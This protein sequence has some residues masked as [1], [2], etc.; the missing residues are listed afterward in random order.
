LTLCRPLECNLFP[1]TT[2]FRSGGN[3]DQANAYQEIESFDLEGY[4]VNMG[5][6]LDETGDTLY[7]GE[8]ETYLSNDELGRYVWVDGEVEELE[9]RKSTRLNSS[10]VSISYAVF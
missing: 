3:K 4:V 5:F 9:D 2:L 10:H 1:Y 8:E 6:Y 7:W